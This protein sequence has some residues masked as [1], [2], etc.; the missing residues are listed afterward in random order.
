MFNLIYIYYK[1]FILQEMKHLTNVGHPFLKGTH[2]KD[3]LA[4]HAKVEVSR[5]VGL[6]YIDYQPVGTGFRVGEKYIM[7]CKHV[8]MKVISRMFLYTIILI[9]V[10]KT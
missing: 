3:V 6:I 7:T 4:S 8:V 5:S 10:Q 2:Q 1:D 9:N